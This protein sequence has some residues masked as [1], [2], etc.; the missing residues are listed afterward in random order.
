[1]TKHKNILLEFYKSQNIRIAKQ[2]KNK[3]FNKLNYEWTKESLNKGYIYNFKWMGIPIIKFPSDLVVLQEIIFEVKPDLIIETGVAHGGSLCFL[4]SMQKLYNP[5][6]RTIG[7][8]I[9]FRKHNEKNCSKIFKQ[10]KIKVLK[11]SSTDPGTINKLKKL[12]K[13]KKVM[14]IL[15]SDHSH[16]HVLNELNLYSNLVSKNSYLICTDT[17]IEEMPKGFFLKDWQTKRA[18][19]R[20]FDKGNSPLTALKL[21]MKNNKN[22]KLMNKWHY[23]AMV[24]E[25]PFGFLKKIK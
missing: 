16:E 11:N 6:A 18:S 9:D 7:V 10:L 21:F 3:K 22:F 15:D 1:M 8:E 17:I 25:S 19:R 20:N 4:A 14:V 2:Y 13:N 24:T 23:K 5:K 12:S